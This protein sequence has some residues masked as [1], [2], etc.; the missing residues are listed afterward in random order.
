[1]P[2]KKNTSP[3]LEKARPRAAALASIDAKLDLGNSLTL[4]GYTAQIEAVQRQLD[5]YNRL[6]SLVEEAKNKLEAGEK[7]LAGLSEQMLIGVAYKFGKDSNEYEKAGGGAQKRAQGAGPPAQAGDLIIPV[8]S[9]FRWKICWD[10]PLSRPSGTL[11]PSGG[12]MFSVLE[13]VFS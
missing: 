10:F 6:L 8:T 5:D 11:S 3:A 9:D 13:S 1:M 4:A 7:A 2:R 12:E